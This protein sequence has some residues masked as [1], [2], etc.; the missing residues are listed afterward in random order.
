MELYRRTGSWMG[1]WD[2]RILELL[3]KDGPQSPKK[4]ADREFIRTTSS[5]VSRRFSA[6]ADHGLVKPLGNGVYQITRNGRLYLVGGYDAETG[7]M[8][9]EQEG[10]G[11]RPYD[12]TKIYLDEIWDA[13]RGQF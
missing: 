13:L 12:W 2:D 3:A 5:N 1:A 10:E 6:L 8:L 11:I 9:I 4:I 7:M